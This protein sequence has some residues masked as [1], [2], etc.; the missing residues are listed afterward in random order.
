MHA[1]THLSTVCCVWSLIQRN[2]YNKLRNHDLVSAAEYAHCTAKL[3]SEPIKLQ[4]KES[5]FVYGKCLRCVS[6]CVYINFSIRR[7]KY[8]QIKT[9]KIMKSIF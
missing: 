9:S 7:H 6:V 8:G 4:S 2:A 5:Y 3:D 1:H